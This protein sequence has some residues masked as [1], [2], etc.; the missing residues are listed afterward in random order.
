[1]TTFLLVPGFWIGGWA[2][3]RVADPLRA[4]GHDVHAVTLAGGDLAGDIAEVTELVQRLPEPATLVGHSY[5]GM[6]VTG[7]ADRVPDRVARLVYVDSGPLPPGTAQCDLLSPADRQ[8]VLDGVAE[9]GPDWHIPVP[10]FDNAELSDAD[11]AML[12]ERAVPQ[13][14]GTSTQPMPPANP[15]RRGIPTDAIACTFPVDVFEQM[16]AAGHPLTVELATHTDRRLHGLPTG[17]WPMFTRP[18]DL[19]KLLD[20]LA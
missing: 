13:P 8:A 2:W 4:A 17:H 19:T 11:L 10:A 16:M 20:S 3:D 12:R 6:V 14:A 5:G 7:T 15:A 9:H 1:M 18:A